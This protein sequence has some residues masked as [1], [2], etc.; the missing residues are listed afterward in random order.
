MDEPVSVAINCQ[1]TVERR[2][3]NLTAEFTIEMGTCIRHGAPLQVCDRGR[4][5]GA[6]VIYPPG[7]YPPPWYEQALLNW[8][9]LR[10][11]TPRESLIGYRWL[12]E[13]DKHHPHE[14]HVYLLYLGVL[15]ELHGKGIG[16]ALLKSLTSQ[17]DEHRHACYLITTTPQNVVLYSRHGFEVA[18]EHSIFG[19]PVWYMWRQAK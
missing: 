12:A 17:A 5:L 14:P 7:S 1:S 2:Q 16:S 19:L 13:I 11:H 15:P 8:T 9:T 4:V 6:A 3:K 18:E 10:I